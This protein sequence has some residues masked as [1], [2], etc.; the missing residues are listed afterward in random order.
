MTERN[1]VWA[2]E[3]ARPKNKNW[4][5]VYDIWFIYR[6]RLW[7]LYGVCAR[8]CMFL[9]FVPL[10]FA[11]GFFLFLLCICLFLC[12]CEC[13]SIWH[14]VRLSTWTHRCFCL[15]KNSTNTLASIKNS[16][17]PWIGWYFR[18]KFEFLFQFQFVCLISF[19]CNFVYS[20]AVWL[21]VCF[22]LDQF[23]NWRPY[24]I[25]ISSSA[26]ASMPFKKQWARY[27]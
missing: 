18:E 6:A 19:C 11:A 20:F 5:S 12:V 4:S 21:C 8:S 10:W 14:A 2:S 27:F 22:V 25:L 15:W 3:R 13:V 1:C 26:A 16:S 23:H 24:L 9:R 7:W 17:A